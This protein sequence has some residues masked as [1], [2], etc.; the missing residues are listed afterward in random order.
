MSPLLERNIAK[1]MPGLTE[2]EKADLLTG[3]LAD[4][5]TESNRLH[6]INGLLF[7]NVP[8]LDI[9]SGTVTRWHVASL[10]TE[11]D[12]HTPHWHSTTAEY[13]GTRSDMFNLLASTI[14]SVDVAAVRGFVLCFL[15]LIAFFCSRAWDSLS[16]SVPHSCAPNCS[17]ATR[18]PFSGS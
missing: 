5:F 3:D 12:I 13:G 7:C 6:T 10:G 14:R 17:S 11:T 2:E 1:Y 4:A 15:P 18:P 9:V 16:L 8:G